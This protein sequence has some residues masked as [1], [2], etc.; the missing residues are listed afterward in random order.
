M[1]KKSEATEVLAK[2]GWN[3]EHTSDFG[4]MYFTNGTSKIRVSDH[5]VPQTPEREFNSSQGR[6]GWDAT[7]PQVILPARDLEKQIEQAI[8]LATSS[9]T[10]GENE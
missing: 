7:A 6:K 8:E 2:K 9:E 10:N 3:I 4:S 1:A 5:Y